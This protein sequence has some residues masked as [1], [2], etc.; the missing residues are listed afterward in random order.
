MSVKEGQGIEE[1]QN[2]LLEMF[3]INEIDFDNENIIT[4]VRHKTLI[5]EAQV[6]LEEA[7]ETANSD[8]PIDI[9]AINIKDII[10][11]LSKITGESVSEDILNE[12]FSK[13]CLG[14]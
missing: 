6:A 14:K 8:M 2:K 12:I 4:N 11:N 10:E 13:F 1:L 9:I 7:E 3:N 5:E